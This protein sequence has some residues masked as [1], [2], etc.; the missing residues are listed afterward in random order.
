MIIPW[1]V[2]YWYVVHNSMEIHVDGMVP[3]F[4]DIGEQDQSI[5]S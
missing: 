5:N 3:K 4:V 1:V 2:V